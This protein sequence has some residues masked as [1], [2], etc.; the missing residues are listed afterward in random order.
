M[1]SLDHYILMV[2]GTTMKTK[3]ALVLNRKETFSDGTIVQIVVWTLPIPLKG[4]LHRYKYRLYFG[5]DGTCLVRYDNEHGK[6]DHKHVAGLEEP[7]RFKDVNTL[8]D[9]FWEDV[10]RTGDD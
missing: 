3:A 6:G 5:K 9:N 10:E 8:L 2:Y 4:S 1:K 7:Y